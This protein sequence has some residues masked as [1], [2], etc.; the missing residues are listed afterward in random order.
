[1]LNKEDFEIIKRAITIYIDRKEQLISS[2]CL[3]TDKTYSFKQQLEYELKK[4][5]ELQEKLSNKRKD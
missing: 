4:I 5:Y 3:D 1:M 2:Y